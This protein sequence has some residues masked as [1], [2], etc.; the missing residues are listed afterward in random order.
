ME[1]IL[2]TSNEELQKEI[3]DLTPIELDDLLNQ[4]GEINEILNEEVGL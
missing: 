1:E 4:I 2:N 3:D